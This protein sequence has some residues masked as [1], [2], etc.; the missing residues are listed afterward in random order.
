MRAQIPNCPKYYPMYVTY[1][2]A[3]E[4]VRMKED[5]Y[6]GKNKMTEEERFKAIL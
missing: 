2:D 1:K 4:E 6:I 5:Y 3:I